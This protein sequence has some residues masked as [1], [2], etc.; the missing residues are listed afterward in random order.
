MRQILL[1]VIFAVAAGPVYGQVVLRDSTESIE[2]DPV[3]VTATRSEKTLERVPVPTSL[4]TAEEIRERGAV[5]LSDVLADQVGLALVEDHGTGVQLQGF[6]AAY[7]LILIDGDPV[8]GRTAG[9]L[10][11]DRLSVSDVERVEIVRGPSSSLYGSEALAG[12]I[13][14]ITREPRE[15]LGGSL[16]SRIQTHGTTSLTADAEMRG[17]RTGFRFTADR[18]ASDGYDLSPGVP[19]LTAPGFTDY[20][21]SSALT[22]RLSESTSLRVNGR[23][24]LQDQQNEALVEHESQSIL[25]GDFASRADWSISPRIEHRFR[26]GLVLEG[27]LYSSR[28]RTNT[29]LTHEVTDERFSESEFD[30][31]FHRAE[32]QVDA[33]VASRHLVTL[34]AGVAA[35]SVEA[36]RIR[37]DRQH[38]TSGF[39]L[40][41][42]EFSPTPWIDVISSGRVDAHSAYGTH[43]SPKIAALVRPTGH[44]RFRASV[45]SGFKAPT[46]QQL[47]LDFANPTAG[48]SVVG[49]V[50][51]ADA[52][53]DLDAAGQV[54][55][56]LT[57]L[58]G[59]EEVGPETSVAIN[60]GFEVEPFAWLDG[61]VNLF[62]NEVSNLIETAPVAV[63]PNGQS[64]YTYFNLNK[65]YTRGVEAEVAIRPLRSLRI[66]T[67]YQL[68][69]ARDRDVLQAIDDGLLYKRVDGRDRRVTRGEYGGLMNR[70]RHMLN[71][72]FAFERPGFSASVRGQY[73]SRYGFGDLNGNLVLDD[74]REYVAGYWLWNVTLTRTLFRGISVQAGARNLFNQTEPAYVPSLSGRL[75]H[76]GLQLDF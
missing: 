15:R 57:S 12:V 28:Y 65:I 8:I 14:I 37:G 42:H 23:L 22:S 4:I 41:Q 39:G 66:S 16:S 44:L 10:D 36:D 48:Y 31:Q 21:L 46:F 55:R 2:L 11:L 51:A 13:N 50:D 69:D 18:Y 7:T 35:E 49:S 5:R 68:L 58:E 32:A 27:R 71:L 9:T 25:A 73:R 70:S 76:A 3:V 34:G 29:W 63:K 53:R 38:M 56:F 17:E 26:P 45:G 61:R 24:S 6:D 62:H 20:T 60:L 30:Q 33:L 47:Y 74:A 40:V 64:I 75:L 67:G 19:G 1:A 72:Q 59:L 52:L 43:I 54:V